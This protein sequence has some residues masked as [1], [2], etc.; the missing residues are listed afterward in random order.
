MGTEEWC[1]QIYE[2]VLRV[3]GKPISITQTNRLVYKCPVCGKP[4]FYLYPTVGYCHKCNKIFMMKE[5]KEILGIGL[6][7]CEHLPQRAIDKFWGDDIRKTISENK[8]NYITDKY[9]LDMVYRLIFDD[10]LFKPL[11]I[12]NKIHSFPYWCNVPAIYS[13]SYLKNIDDIFFKDLLDSLLKNYEYIPGVRIEF[14]NYGQVE[15]LDLINFDIDDWEMSFSFTV[16]ESYIFMYYGSVDSIS[17]IL[18]YNA[19]VVNPGPDQPKYKWA[20]G[21]KK[22]LFIPY[23]TSISFENIY[24]NFSIITEGEK[25][26][27]ALCDIG[28]KTVGVAGVNCF[29]V[30]ELAEYNG[31]GREVLVLYDDPENN[32]A[33]LRA[34]KKLC[35]YLKDRNFVPIPIHIPDK[36]DDY[37]E[38]VG[39]D[40]FKGFLA[41]KKAKYLS[42]RR[43]SWGV[44]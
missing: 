28:L 7:S 9:I 38:K 11:T 36:V 14:L 15:K 12:N 31:N 39:E 26:A 3:M 32:S 13:F 37:L 1:E 30:P 34:E 23:D 35:R 4:K 19:K 27:I 44:E 43:S 21:T 22:H 6:S 41:E 10:L 33:V 29:R 25:K 40:A 42:R 18:A 24:K 8:T 17:L 20:A 2:E 16:P 5:M